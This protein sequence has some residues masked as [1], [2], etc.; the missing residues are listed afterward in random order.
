MQR[1]SKA[2]ESCTERCFFLAVS[3]E[4]GRP[5]LF[6]EEVEHALRVLRMQAGEVLTG[7]DGR[8]GAFPL[9]IVRADRHLL[10]LE[11][12]GLSWREP[13]PGEVDAK[14]P[15]IEVAAVLPRGSRA[16]DLVDALV[17]LGAAAIT[18]LA[19]DRAQGG[20]SDVSSARAARLERAAREACKQSR[21]TWMP[22][23]HPEIALADLLEARG[24]AAVC[25]LHPGG[26]Q[27]LAAWTRGLDRGRFGSA[28]AP[29]VLLIGPEGGFSP[30]ELDRLERHGVARAAL[31]PH[32]LRIETAAAAALAVA[33][34]ALYRAEPGGA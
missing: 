30:A 1:R 22:A 27:D 16:E 17:Q 19:T 32:V 12:A 7:L 14:L 2:P 21:R 34:Q 20:R 15:W 24:H 11:P 18:P 6:R 31:G 4:E 28:E 10:E 33:V 26:L 25:A 13:A 9:R 23:L 8:G 3:P 29:I 5:E